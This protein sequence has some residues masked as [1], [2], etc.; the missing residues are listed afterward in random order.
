M[1]PFP[2][3]YVSNGMCRLTLWSTVLLLFLAGCPF[4]QERVVELNFKPVLDSASG[5]SATLVSLTKARDIS[6]KYSTGGLYLLTH[7]GDFDSLFVQANQNAIDHPLISESW[8]YCSV[9]AAL[10]DSSAMMGRNWDNQNVGSIIIS[11]CLPERGFASVSFARG[12]D[13]GFPLNVDIADFSSTDLGQRLLLAPFYAMDG[14]NERGLAVAVVGVKQTVVRAE[15]GKELV[16][17]PYLVRKLLDMAG[18]LQEAVN[19]AQNTVPFDLDKNSLNSHLL[20]TDS[21][22]RSVILEYANNQW[23]CIYSD[24]AWQVL[25]NKPVFNVTDSLLRESCWRYRTLSDALAK[26]GDR[27]HWRGG[28][29]LLKEVQQQGTTW[30]VMYS[31]LTKELHFSIYQD[32]NVIYHLKAF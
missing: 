22:G 31:T 28:L 2:I 7:R 9:F 26:R 19:L 23:Q 32:W 3:R 29:D 24:N 13:M 8:R 4:A 14:M 18:N 15:T 6:E 5:T 1:K 21:S 27:L 20:L 25:T 10:A 16:F 12:I 17:V 30:S 11:L